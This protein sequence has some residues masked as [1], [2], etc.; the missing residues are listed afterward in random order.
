MS[1]QQ[2]TDLIKKLYADFG[3]GDIPAILAA[4]ADDVVWIFDG[5]AIIPFTGT[6]KGPSQVLG[7]F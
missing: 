4:L 1:E 3:R 5:P 2:N 6:R 7:F